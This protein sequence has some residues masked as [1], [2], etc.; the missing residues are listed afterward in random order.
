MYLFDNSSVLKLLWFLLAIIYEYVREGK[1]KLISI[2]G[3][4]LEMVDSLNEHVRQIDASKRGRRPKC[5]LQECPLIRAIS[6]H[7]LYNT[8]VVS[9]KTIL[10]NIV[11]INRKESLSLKLGFDQTRHKNNV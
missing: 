11:S 3:Q 4:R 2:R 7:K 9:H 5:S 6:I 1:C 8:V 10:I